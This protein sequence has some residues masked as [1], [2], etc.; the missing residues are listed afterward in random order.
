MTEENITQKI[1]NLLAEIKDDDLSE[2]G[3]ETLSLIK[4]AF[5][6]VLFNTPER[7]PADGKINMA[8]VNKE[9]GQKRGAIYHY[10]DFVKQARNI[11]P[12]YKEWE[13][14]GGSLADTSESAEL[15]ALMNENADLKY[16]NNKLKNDKEEAFELRDAMKAHAD[17][18]MTNNANL[19]QALLTKLYEIEQ[20][21]EQIERLEQEKA[22]LAKLIQLQPVK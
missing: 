9:A 19:E 16:K 13:K 5:K 14:N 22:N 20:L 17:K 12:V 6:R 7:T 4:D 15:T 11:I 1:D 21:Q 8:K 2:K 3:S 10:K 18:V